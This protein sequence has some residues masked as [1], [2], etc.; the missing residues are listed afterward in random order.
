MFKK[1]WWWWE[2]ERESESGR[3][4]KTNEMR[5]QKAKTKSNER[6]P[7]NHIHLLVMVLNGKRTKIPRIDWTLKNLRKKRPSAFLI[8]HSQFQMITIIYRKMFKVTTEQFNNNAAASIRSY[9]L[10]F[11]T[12][13]H[14]IQTLSRVDNIPMKIIAEI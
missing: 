6:I 8:D 7:L 10:G 14:S 3:D 2:Q 11:T 13:E 12:H 5:S 9:K 1:C 4:W